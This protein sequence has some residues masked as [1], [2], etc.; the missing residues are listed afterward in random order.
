MVNLRGMDHRTGRIKQM[1]LFRTIILVA[2]AIILPAT[3]WSEDFAKGQE[4]YFSGDY[5]TAMTEWQPLADAGQMDSQYGMG[6]LYA[7]GFGVDM[8][9]EQ[10]LKW[11]GLAADQGHAEAQVQSRGYA[12]KW[13]GSTA[14]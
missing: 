13:L 5:Q 10:A 9:D 7:N 1:R 4:A 14:K 2:T 8:N 11:Y 12:C 6:L 3:S